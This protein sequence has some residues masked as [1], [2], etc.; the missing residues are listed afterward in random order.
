MQKQSLF[1]YNVVIRVAVTS[2]NGILEINLSRTVLIQKL[3]N[4]K[5]YTCI[6]KS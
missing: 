6:K 5:I 2:E 1:M 3:K 4:A